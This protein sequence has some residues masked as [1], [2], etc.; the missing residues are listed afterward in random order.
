VKP[1]SLIKRI[2]NSFDDPLSLVTINDG[3]KD[4]TAAPLI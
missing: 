2:K 3:N 1:A 4:P